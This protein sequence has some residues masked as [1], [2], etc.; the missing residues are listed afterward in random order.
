MDGRGPFSAGFGAD[1]LPGL[2]V[3]GGDGEKYAMI[4]FNRGSRGATSLLT[5]SLAA[6]FI[7][8][9]SCSITFSEMVSDIVTVDAARYCKNEDGRSTVWA[10][11]FSG[12]RGVCVGGE[13]ASICS[14]VSLCRGMVRFTVVFPLFTMGLGGFLLVEGVGCAG[15]SAEVLGRGNMLEG[16][17][18]YDIVDPEVSAA[19]AFSTSGSTF[20][21]GFIEELE[22]LT[23]STVDTDVSHTDVS[24]ISIVVGTE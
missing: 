6:S 21:T 23:R 24:A 19:S 3:V 14:C 13:W 8:G 12:G 22:V 11:V 15:G 17:G 9:R 1:C 10:F 7:S 2:S 20:S 16:S 18:V 5:A 4:V